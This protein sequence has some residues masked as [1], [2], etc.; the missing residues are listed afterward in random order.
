M[1]LLRSALRPLARSLRAIKARFIRPL[2]ERGLWEQVRQLGLFDDGWYALVNPDVTAAGADPFIHY[3][4][5]GWQEGRMPSAVI[6]RMR[7]IRSLMSVDHRRCNPLL[8]ILRR[9]Q[10]GELGTADLEPLRVGPGVTRHWP[11]RL[12]CREGVLLSGYFSS[13]IGLGQSARLF[14][15]AM[16]MV[17][18]PLSM[19]DIRLP[20]RESERGF[21]TKTDS[22]GAR[23][24][25]AFLLGADVLGEDVRL[26]MEGS[27]KVL[28]LFWELAKLPERWHGAL[29]HFDAVWAPSE[30]VATA[31]KS[32]G[33]DAPLIRQPVIAPVESR[34]V[35][36]RASAEPLSV[37][38]Y[39]DFDSYSARK[40]VR[41]AVTAFRTAF[42]PGH[43]ASMTVKV[44]GV[45]DGT[46]RAWLASQVAEDRRIRVIDATLQW[47]EVDEL[48][49]NCDVFLSMHRSEGFG[50]GAAEA[51]GHGKAVV[52][53]D[54]GGTVDFVNEAT[55][56][57]VACRLV[58]V[59]R[60]EYIGWE[61]Q[62]W[63]DP[64][65][66]HAAELLRSIDRDRATAAAKGRE[67]REWVLANLAPA[68]VG[69]VMRDWLTGRGWL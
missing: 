28:I 60:G 9:V 12:S 35:P 13:E 39:L 69:R 23:R 7:D 36:I 16:D 67:G 26:P 37:L 61:G 22:T 10:R 30:I 65:I 54:Y 24:V 42:R 18:I 5:H 49:R 56:Y 47:H 52:S 32:A 66:E 44:R 4:A 63:A 68:A 14:S 51:L 34:Y 21:E 1:S 64:S 15:H 29:R 46:D 50:F 41:A 3:M 53:T 40:N 27:V 45:T 55:G 17:R 20:G 6:G 48:V 38:T 19:R 31:L 11:Q 25:H 62:E 43:P 2:H 58:P 59:R 57:P 8:E 33:I